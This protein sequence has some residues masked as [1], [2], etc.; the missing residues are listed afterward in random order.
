MSV[1]LFSDY[2]PNNIPWQKEAVREFTNFDYSKGVL[3]QFFSGSVG[4]AKTAEHIHQIVRH[5]LENKGARFLMV[6][7]ALKDLKRTSWKEMQNHISGLGGV[8]RSNNKSDLAVTFTNGSE[9]IGDS[10]D[11]GDLDKF[12][13]LN[14]SGLD[15]EE[16]TEMPFDVYEILYLRLGRLIGVEKNIAQLRSNPDSPTHWLYTYFI[17]NKSDLK[18]VHYSLTEQNPFLPSWYAENIRKKYSPKMVR[19]MLYGEWL[20]INSE[21]IYENY[22]TEVNFLRDT[23]YK[24]NP[25]YPLCQFHDFNIGQGKPM[26]AGLGQW[27]DGTAHVFK[28]FEVQGARTGD[29]I[30]EMYE[31]G[32]YQGISTVNLYGDASGKNNDTRSKASDYDIIIKYLENKNIRVVYNVPRSNPPLRRRHNLMNGLFRNDL[33]EVRFFLYKGCEFAD[34]GFRLTKPKAGANLLEDDSLPNQHI[35]TAIGYWLDFESIS[36][37]SKRIQL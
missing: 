7:R 9:I 15:V 22:N 10:Y 34:K 24:I 16:A 8:I 13:S 23:E 36:T 2:N 29:I 18:R 26:S 17:E 28:T 14:I 33:G 27:I 25:H 21:V 3:E 19:R 1:P 32:A 12:K 30:E 11:N 20:E 4:S 6:R 35:T 37:P 5:C 31:S